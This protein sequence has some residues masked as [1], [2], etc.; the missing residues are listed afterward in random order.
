M[1]EHPSA[2]PA[3]RGGAETSPAVPAHDDARHEHDHEHEPHGETPDAVHDQARDHDHAASQGHDHDHEHPTG[4]RG[5]LLDLLPFRHAHSHAGLT[6][7][8]TLETSA[9]GIWALK[10]GLLGLGATAAVQLVVALLNGADALTAIPLWLAFVLGR[11]PPTRRYTYGYG[12]AEDVAG[13]LIVGII[14]VSAGLAAWESIRKLLAPTPPTNLIWVAVAA[15]VGFLGN[16]G[17]AQF[18]IRIG[19]EIGSAALIA[20]GQHARADGF[21]SLAVLVGVIGVAL[22]FPI[23]DP[24]IGLLITLA[25][26]IIARDTALTMWQ[27]LMDAVDPALV[28]QVEATAGAVPGVQEAHDVRM[29]WLGHR[30]EAELHIT[31]D[32]DLPTRTSHAIIEAVRHDLFHA[33]PMLAVVNVHADPGGHSVED[34]HAVTAH[35]ATRGQGSGVRD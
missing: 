12:R 26:L 5:I 34:A 16:E 21:T 25:I 20:D 30:L 9:R 15:V 19:N 35:H 6:G 2:D 13:V 28:D 29:R 22:G 8:D 11:R 32:E 27:R 24:L 3:P 18:R 10:V 33:L 1:R 31:V 4:L 17:V 7:D 14:F 23:A